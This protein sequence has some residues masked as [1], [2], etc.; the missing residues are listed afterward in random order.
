MEG[1]KPT[2]DHHYKPRKNSLILKVASA[3]TR[4]TVP[5]RLVITSRLAATVS[6]SRRYCALRSACLGA[7]KISSEHL[8]KAQTN[9][10]PQ[11]YR[12]KEADK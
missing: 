10:S 11:R 1:I 5:P 6:R 4:Q 7:L 9:N 12:K 8:T 3:A 2:I